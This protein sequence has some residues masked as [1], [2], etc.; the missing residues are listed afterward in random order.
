MT[1]P[2]IPS[3]PVWR[4][5]NLRVALKRMA[6]DAHHHDDGS[7]AAILEVAVRTVDQRIAEMESTP[8]VQPVSEI[9]TQQV[10]RNVRIGQRRTTIKM[11]AE[12]WD[13][14][15]A[16]AAQQESSLDTVCSHIASLCDGGNLTSAIRVFVLRDALRDQKNRLRRFD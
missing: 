8:A 2:A 9:S 5:I 11:E 4:D 10:C 12:F 14:L 16:M 13:A 7:L 3:S 1:K 6:D 15:E